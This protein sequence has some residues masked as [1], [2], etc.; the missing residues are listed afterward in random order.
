[1]GLGDQRT[2]VIVNGMKPPNNRM[3]AKWR[4]SSS[5]WIARTAEYSVRPSLNHFAVASSASVI[6]YWRASAP[7]RNRSRVRSVAGSYHRVVV[8]ATPGN[9]AP[10]RSPFQGA[11]ITVNRG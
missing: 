6:Q 11:A 5:S 2:G 10:A 8:I 9:A 1:V 4:P 3:V 7:I